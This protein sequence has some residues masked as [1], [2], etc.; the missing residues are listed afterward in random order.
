MVK[1]SVMQK[2]KSFNKLNVRK[3]SKQKNRNAMNFLPVRRVAAGISHV[4]T[5]GP[6]PQVMMKSTKPPNVVAN[7]LSL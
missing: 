7:T 3:K 2:V 1:D 4:D 6:E 5:F